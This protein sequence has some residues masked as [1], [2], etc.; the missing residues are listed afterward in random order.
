MVARRGQAHRGRAKRASERRGAAQFPLQPSRMRPHVH[1]LLAPCARPSPPLTPPLTSPCSD[2][3]V[4]SMFA[5]IINRLRAKM[6]KEVRVQGV[7]RGGV[8]GGG[9]VQGGAGDWAVAVQ[10]AGG[11]LARAVGRGMAMGWAGEAPPAPA[12][13]PGGARPLC[14]AAA[15]PSPHHQ[16]T[17]NPHHLHPT[18]TPRRCPSFLAPS[19]SAR[20]K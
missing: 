5:M 11:P 6:D 17:T 20:C 2:A 10:R 7:Q 9:A 15:H 12:H 16:P 3:E 19:S 8:G 14:T 13:T 1:A 18:P 4:L